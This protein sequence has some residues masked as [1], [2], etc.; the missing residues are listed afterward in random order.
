MNWAAAEA[1]YEIAV[2]EGDPTDPFVT[3][4]QLHLG[5]IQDVQGDRKGARKTYHEVE[6]LLNRWGTERLA[7]RYLKNPFDPALHQVRLLPD[8]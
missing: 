4:A 3:W 2:A 5:N 1:A 7:E 8:G 6:D